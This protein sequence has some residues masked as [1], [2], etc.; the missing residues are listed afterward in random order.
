MTSEDAKD[1][2]VRLT[3]ASMRLQHA[4]ETARFLFG[5]VDRLY[6]NMS[7]QADNLYRDKIF[8][9]EVQGLADAAEDLAERLGENNG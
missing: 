4:L 5:N 2:A 9:A 3:D 8:F 7:L 6:A 1:L